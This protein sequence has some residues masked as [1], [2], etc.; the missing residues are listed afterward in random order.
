M[1]F[2]PG[3]GMLFGIVAGVVLH[4]IPLGVTFGLIAELMFAAIRRRRT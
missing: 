2:P 3:L 1:K 4:N